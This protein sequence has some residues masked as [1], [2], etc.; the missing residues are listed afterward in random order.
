MGGNVGDR[1]VVTISRKGIF[2]LREA[3]EILPVIRKITQEFSQKVEVLIARLET[4]DPSQTAEVFKLETLVNTLIQS[5]NEKIRKLGGQPKGLWLVDFDSGEG[6]F[7]WKFP[8]ADIL[9]WH[10]YEDGFTNR[11]SIEDYLKMDPK[12]A[13]HGDKDLEHPSRWP[14]PPELEI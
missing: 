4:M 2:S 13:G 9:F 8:E 6:Y 14:K 10:G 7:C 12:A 3:K 5:W 11:T 1:G